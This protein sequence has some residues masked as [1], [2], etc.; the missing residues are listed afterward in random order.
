M[1]SFLGAVDD[2]QGLVDMSAM[3]YNARGVV[4]TSEKSDSS[5]TIV[6]FIVVK[7]GYMTCIMY[8]YNFRCA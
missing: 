4:S 5:C 3:T 6:E 1:R 7:V 8:V 2:L